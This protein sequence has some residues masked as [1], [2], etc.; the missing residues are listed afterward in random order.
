MNQDQSGTPSSLPER[1]DRVI[2]ELGRH[3][4]SDRIDDR[5]FE[6]RIDRAYAAGS[7]AELELLQS[8]LPALPRDPAMAVSSALPGEPV[9]EQQSL[10][11][12]LGGTE[13]KGSWRPARRIHAV[14]LMGGLDLDFRDAQFAPGVTELHVLAMMGGVD[15]VVPPGLRVEC[16]GFGLLGGFGDLNQDG[17]PDDPD[18]P[19]LRVRGLA[20]LGGVDVSERRPGESSR[21]R[22]RR[23][24][25]ERREQ[26]RLGSG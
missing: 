19:T 14:A 3:F 6:R 11:A 25:V 5:E 10:I 12:V 23:L 17:D 1:R 7:L 20:L 22:K 13:R 24:K 4:A 8:D 15:I 2:A 9:R 21:D 18:R 26:G 16:E